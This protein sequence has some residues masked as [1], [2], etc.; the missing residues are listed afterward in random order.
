MSHPEDHCHPEAPPAEPGPS[1]RPRPARTRRWFL[2]MA[3][4]LTGILVAASVAAFLTLGSRPDVVLPEGATIY[5]NEACGD[6]LTYLNGDLLP[7]LARAGVEP[8]LV[9]DYINDRS[10][11]AELTALNGALGIPFELQSHL[12]TF[13]SGATLTAFEGHVP[14]ALI[15]EA[16]GMNASARPER[17]LVFQDSMGAVVAYRAWAFAGMPQMYPI[18]TSLAVYVAWYEA[19]VGGPDPGGPSP[20]LLPLVLATGLL[21]GLNPCAFAVLLFFVSFLY[22]VR[23]PRAE[24]LRMG[25]IYAYAVFLVYFLIGLGILGAIVVSED[26]HLIAKVA[27]IAVIALGSFSLLRILVPGLPAIN[28][29]PQ[30]SWPRIK[31]RILEGSVPSATAAGLLV[32]LCT[33]PCSGGVYVAIL[34]LLASNT[35]FLEGLGYLYLY[36]GMYI[37]PLLLVLAAVSNRRLALAVPRPPDE[38][39]PR[40]DDGRDG[41]RPPRPLPV[42]APSES[43][44]SARCVPRGQVGTAVLRARDGEAAP[45]GPP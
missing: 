12:V 45:A 25:G 42:T 28:V 8:V 13:V 37:L 23:A 9:K 2:G 40:R 10:F 35:G 31:A 18:D 32:G 21:D 38:G 3:F 7:S 29:M 43:L 4:A 22:A 11:R 39:G 6:C 5:F 34:G 26:P 15:E 36:N 17:I 16:L 33:F 14:G 27:A 19:N 24:V 41:G 30:A 1:P 20:A 44:S